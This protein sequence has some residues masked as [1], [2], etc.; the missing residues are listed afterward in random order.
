MVYVFV[1]HSSNSDRFV[2]ILANDLTAE[3]IDTFVDHHHIKGG[4]R[5]PQVVREALDQCQKM[6]AI[7][8]PSSIESRNCQNEWYKFIQENKEVIPVWLSGNDRYF[9]FSLI[10][11]VDFR[12]GNDYKKSFRTL[13]KY[14]RDTTDSI[15]QMP[16]NLYRKKIHLH[17]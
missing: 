3:G 10:Q 17:L 12:N 14:L 1:S 11:G 7:I 15:P 2:D 13:V 16:L 9:E 8:S 6:I 5:W 4:Q